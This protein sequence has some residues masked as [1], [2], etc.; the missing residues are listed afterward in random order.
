MENKKNHS[1]L[2]VEPTVAD[3]LN[4]GSPVVALESTIITHGMPYP[5]NV[6]T[7]LSVEKAVKAQGAVPATIGII[8]G[9]V[10]VGLN[11]E[12]ISY[13]ASRGPKVTKVSRR[14]I[15]LIMSR[16]QDG[17]TTV[18]ATLIIAAMAGIR[19]MATGGIGGVHRGV[20]ETMDISA[21]LQELARNTIAVV[22]SGVK[23]VLDIAR[24]TEYLETVGVP[25]VGYRT[26][27]LP[28]FYARESEQSVDYRM[29][30]AADVAA[31]LVAKLHTNIDG[32]ILVAN[33]VP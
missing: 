4:D 24:T 31:A 29:N 33:P 27:V 15:P 7:A 10:T 21:D 32:A 11:N 26:D 23:S 28:A 1:P 18:A 8:G 6:E 2:I 16:G 25:I 19:V 17:A 22:C 5:S 9:R 14:D 12:E 30:G 3:A 20:E 13:L